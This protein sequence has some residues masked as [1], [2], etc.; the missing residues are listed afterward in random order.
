[1]GEIDRMRRKPLLAFVLTETVTAVFGAPV[2]EAVLV[3]IHMMPGHIRTMQHKD[4]VV[5]TFS[6]KCY[7]EDM[8][9]SALREVIDK[10][11]E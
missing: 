4:K 7:A 3:A 10:A 8:F 5:C 9:S 1:M 11:Q 2:E 6:T